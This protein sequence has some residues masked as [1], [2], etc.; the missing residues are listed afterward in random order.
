MNVRLKFLHLYF[1][2]WFFIADAMN[3]ISFLVKLVLQMVS[4]LK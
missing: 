2:N 1:L 4:M 3:Q